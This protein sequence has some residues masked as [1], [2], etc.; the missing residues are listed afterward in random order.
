MT[1]WLREWRSLRSAMAAVIAGYVML[2][3][4]SL[5]VADRPR[6]IFYYNEMGSVLLAIMASGTLFQRELSGSQMELF[7]AYPASLAG[8]VVRKGVWTLG[9]VLV[10]HP[11]WT[12]VYLW[13]FLGMIAYVSIPWA[14]VGPGAPVSEIDLLAVA[15]P[16]YLAAIGITIA[17][18]VA[19][20]RV[21][22]GLLAGFGFW[23]WQSLQGPGLGSVSL[24]TPYLPQNTS[25]LANRLVWAGIGMVCVAVAAGLA[26]R[27]ERWIGVDSPE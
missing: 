10:F 17:V 12:L 20:K 3:L 15:V 2:V 22:I 19:A 4:L 26:E 1:L 21:H 16:G 8:M 7:A 5:I 18:M 27:R 14:G 9:V 25:L 11:M 13:K 24:F 6:N 23:L